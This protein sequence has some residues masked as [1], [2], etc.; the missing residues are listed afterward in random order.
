MGLVEV[1]ISGH[2]LC[3]HEHTAEARA[4]DGTGWGSFDNAGGRV[5]RDA[6]VCFVYSFVHVLLKWRA[7]LPVGAAFCS[8]ASEDHTGLL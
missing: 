2:D 8:C 7:E 5:G 4:G 6:T 3:L 1:T